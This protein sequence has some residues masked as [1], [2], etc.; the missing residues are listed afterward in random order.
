MKTISEIY[1]FRL[2]IPIFIVSL[3]G[4]LT[5]GCGSGNASPGVAQLDE[6]AVINT[7]DIISVNTAD[8]TSINGGD[9]TSI[10]TA[11]TTSING[12]DTTSINTADTASTNA[13]DPTSEI[14]TESQ[15]STRILSDPTPSPENISEQTD[16]EI[17]TS[18]AECLRSEGIDVPDPELN[19]DGTVNLAAFRQNM[20]NDPNFNFRN[21]N[22]RRSMEKCVP[23]LQTASFAG[24]RTQEDEIELQDNLLEMAECLR[25]AGLNVRDPDF[26]EGRGG[27]FRSMVA[28]LDLDRDSLQL[29]MSE[30]SETIFGNE[31]NRAPGRPGGGRPLRR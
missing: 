26:S 19:A 27:A 30:C 31:R 28:D 15:A 16:E 8:T 7:A 3:V 20:A 11:D 21:P 22:T 1:R 17:T 5:V 12:G 18:F 10:K 9:T 2:I 25:G 4:V 29:A 13:A 23:I 14:Q 6:N 24:Q